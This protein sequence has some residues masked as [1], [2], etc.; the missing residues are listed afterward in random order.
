MWNLFADEKVEELGDEYDWG[1]KINAEA[2]GQVGASASAEGEA[3][4]S[5]QKVGASAKAK[6]GLGLGVGLRA[7]VELTGLD[8]LWNSITGGGSIKS[9]KMGGASGSWG[10]NGASGSW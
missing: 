6:V 5:A 4:A 10:G 8:K 7:G 3:T 9:R 1:I 2:T